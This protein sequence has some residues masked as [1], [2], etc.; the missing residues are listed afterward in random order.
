M[1][2][3]FSSSVPTTGTVDFFINKSL[4]IVFN[5]ELDSTTITNS[6][7]YLYDMT[8]SLNVPIEVERKATD[9]AT[10]VVVPLISLKENSEYRLTVV[11][12]D[13]NL[14][15]QL[16]AANGDLLTVS[17]YILFS[18]GDNVYSIDTTVEKEANSKTLEGDIFLPV[19]VKA[20]GYEFTITK[21]RPPNHSHAITGSLTGVTFTFTKNLLT[22]QDTST[23][24]NIGIYP[25]LQDTMYLAS[26]STMD[27]GSNTITMPNYSIITT[28]NTLSVAFDYALPKNV[29]I[30]IELTSNIKSSDNDYFGGNMRYSSTTELYPPVYGPHFIKN[31]LPAISNLL[32]DDYISSILFK[33]TIWLWERLGRSLNLSSLS[34]PAKKY[35]LYSTILDLIEDKDY[36]KFVV[37]GTRRQLGDLNVSIDNLIGRVAMKAASAKKEKDI[38]FETLVKG[39]QFRVGARCLSNSYFAGTRLWYDINSRYTDE[40]YRYYQPDIPASNLAINRQAQTNNPLQW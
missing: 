23:L 18:T 34:F 20:L 11:G 9:S 14:G 7:V 22:G 35:I 39:W 2:L 28:G 17:T 15:L 25:I 10:I 21:V 16:Q 31:E 1:A 37:A 36:K 5:E 19:N 12:T 32:T 30:T 13:L 8:A 4:E 40:S 27:L 3:T 6:T 26:G 33:N 38:A 29:A 24:A